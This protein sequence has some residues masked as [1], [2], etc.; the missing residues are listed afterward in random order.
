MQFKTIT[1]ME[2]LIDILTGLAIFIAVMVAFRRRKPQMQ[3]RSQQPP[4]ERRHFPDASPADEASD[5]DDEPVGQT[6]ER[7]SDEPTAEDVNFSYETIP[8]DEAAA[9]RTKSASPSAQTPPTPATPPPPLDDE[10]NFPNIDLSEEG[11]KQGII[12]SEIFK[13]RY[14]Q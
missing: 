3:K 8:D 6:C 11:I 14:N 9:S 2:D 5:W 10:S 4:F 12:Y 1:K 7:P 13:P